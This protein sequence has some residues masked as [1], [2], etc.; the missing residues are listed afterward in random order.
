MIIAGAG[1]GGLALARALLAQGHEAT[2][3]ERADGLRTGGAGLTVW[4]NGALCLDRLGISIDGLGNRLDALEVRGA[5]GRSVA[6]IDVRALSERMGAPV[7]MTARAEL[8]RHLHAPL[9]AGT[10]RFGGGYTSHVETPDGVAVTASDGR[11]HVGDLLVGAD[12]AHSAVRRALF[13]DRPTPTTGVA[14][15]FGMIPT[16]LA[17]LGH[18]SGMTVGREGDFGYMEVGGGRLV[19]WFDLP[20]HGSA[21]DKP[22]ELLRKRYGHWAAPAP[23]VLN[24]ITEDDFGIFPHHR[25]RI[26]RTWGR[27]RTTLL[28]DAAHAMPPT[29]AQ[30]MNQTF[31][32][33]VA[34]VDRLGRSPGPGGVAAELRGYEAG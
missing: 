8:L 20:W 34:L 2:V 11:V 32:D 12:G 26:P 16:P 33:V 21:P 24:A 14:S 29:L 19:F 1:I 13:G 3:L 25:H 5:Q 31:E 4:H 18:W 17:P 10:V 9:P 7:T 28:G 23:D 22:L 27:G 6:V 30:G 15:C